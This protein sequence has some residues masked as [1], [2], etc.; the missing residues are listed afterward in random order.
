MERIATKIQMQP[1]RS[2]K[3]KS[4]PIQTES[5]ETSVVDVT[6]F[7]FSRAFSIPV[8]SAAQDPTP[9]IPIIATVDFC[10]RSRISSY[11]VDGVLV[12]FSPQ[13]VGDQLVIDAMGIAGSG[14]YAMGTNG[15]DGWIAVRLCNGFAN[16]SLSSVIMEA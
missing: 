14:T 7:S 11:G 2:N 16:S 13:E 5:F 10:N 15:L 4:K 1:N 3:K 8:A 9:P 6:Y 12:L